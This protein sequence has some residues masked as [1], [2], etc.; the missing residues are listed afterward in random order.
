MVV[1]ASLSG[2]RTLSLFSL[3]VV[4]AI[5]AVGCRPG[6]DPAPPTSAATMAVERPDLVAAVAAAA[7]Q[8]IDPA[9]SPVETPGRSTTTVAP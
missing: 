6:G 2:R 4:A 1:L 9:P 3:L 7:T 5:A 8:A